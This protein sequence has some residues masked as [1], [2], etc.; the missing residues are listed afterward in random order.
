MLA[1]PG[2]G[3]KSKPTMHFILAAVFVVA[4]WL[5]GGASRFDAPAQLL[6]RAASGLVLIVWVLTP[7]QNPL[8]GKRSVGLLLAAI[9]LLVAL[10][11]VP[12]PPALWLSLPGRDLFSL[13]ATI[14]GEPQPWRPLSIA[15]SFTLNALFSLMV[16][17]AA[18]CLFAPLTRQ[19]HWRLVS[20]LLA[21]ALLTAT[22]GVIQV[23]GGHY[24]QPF[25]NDMPGE[26]SA[27]FANRNHAAL[28]LA[29]A[30]LLAPV[31]AIRAKARQLVAI[32]AACAAT[33]L[34]LL[35][36]LGTGSRAGLLLGIA[37]AFLAV[38]LCRGRW[39]L[40][41]VLRGARGLAVAAGVGA[42]TIVLGLLVISSGRA[43]GLDRITSLDTADEMRLRA[44]PTI[45]AMAE[46]YFPVGSGFGTFDPA[47]RISEPTEL[48]RRT[49]LNQAHNDVLQIVVEGG[50][51]AILLLL[52]GLG[53]FAYASVRAWRSRDAILAR[54]GSCILALVIAASVIDYPARTPFIMMLTILGACWLGE[55]P[56]RNVAGGS[57]QSTPHRPKDA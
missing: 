23:A 10:Q 24:D 57:D 41:G 3:N 40:P 32:V 15:P 44:L 20:L 16:P 39:S 42:A 49:Y 50:L 19:Q 18:F 21:L 1:K 43:A 36:I 37:S 55:A 8:G 53:W 47:Y 51:P 31:R 45:I 28:F 5:V 38:L 6:A 33:A 52:A 13:A 7:Q 30:A 54:L 25:V 56:N 27:N 34:F 46:Q 9:A 12:L 35:V 48:L 26:V 4:M 11:L 22:L 2:S 17:V 14:S 29:I